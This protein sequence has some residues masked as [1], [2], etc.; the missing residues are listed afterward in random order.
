MERSESSRDDD[1]T[2]VLEMG[3]A[4]HA[5]GTAAHRLEEVLVAVSSQLGLSGEFFSTPTSI[6]ASF[7]ALA[8]QRTH[9]LRVEPGETDLGRLARVDAVIQE[10]LA[11]R[12]TPEEGV[13]RMAAIRAARD[14]Y[15][16]WLRVVAHGVA[17]FGAAIFFGGSARG[18]GVALL[19]GLLTGAI[20]WL[21][22]HAKAWERVYL[23]LASFAAGVLAT[24]LSHL[25]GGFSVSSAIL[26]GLIVLLPGM[27]LTTAM[28]EL[29]TRHWASGTARLFG[30]FAIFLSLGFGVA[31]GTRLVGAVFGPPIGFAVASV[32]GPWEW[33]AVGVS[34]LAF[35]V[36]LK[37]EPRDLP[38]FALAGTA[39]LLGSRVGSSLLGPELG[40][41]IGALAVG[42]GSSLYARRFR[43]PASITLV[44]GVLILVPGS[45]GFRSVA[46]LMDQQVVSGVETAFRMIVMAVALA[47]GLIL[48]R[49]V[50]PE[51]RMV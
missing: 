44:P 33:I 9:L 25:A 47:A 43:C 20:E 14:R 5:Y 4:L 2:F 36:L 3:R 7:G 32:Q 38:G 37:A 31:L 15:A 6:F 22:Q 51:R 40:V 29:S 46:S 50:S 23:P 34:S 49:I 21:T 12:I 27:T 41:M 45:V 39:A 30:A 24:L 18:W 48:A 35:L 16:G 8:T 10:V 28:T 17:S 42:V 13:K 1:I 19:I 26:A 11:R